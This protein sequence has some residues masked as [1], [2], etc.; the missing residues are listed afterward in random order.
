MEK[1]LSRNLD[2]FLDSDY[3]E[4][5]ELI[6]VNDGSTD[7]TLTIANEYQKS[8]PNT[9]IVIDKPNGHYGSCVNAALK[10]ATGKYFRIVDADDWVDSNSLIKVLQILPNIN[11]H[12][13]YTKYS[14]CYERD[15]QTIINEDPGNLIWYKPLNLNDIR[16]DKYVHMHQ[17][18]YLTNFLRSINYIQT[19]GVC[20]TDTEYVFM[21]IVQAQDV[22]CINVPLYQYFIGRDDQSMSTNVLMKNFSH[23]Y[24]VLLSILD[25]P[26]PS[27]T[28]NNYEFLLRYYV[29]TILGMLVDCLFVSR[30]LNENW[31]LQLHSV[32]N[33]LKSIDFDFSHYCEY[34]VNGCHWFKWWLQD[35]FISRLKLRM[36]FSLISIKH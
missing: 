9:I 7:K 32:C 34:S 13:V 12:V 2:S 15:G 26:R 11:T 14:N 18:T 33:R 25:Y 30:C 16:F 17:I 27:Y 28:N 21:P 3:I 8:Y 31:N 35:T 4:E 23:L 1:Y 24:K 20:Y 22:Y 6:V 5:I 10:I 29:N 36:L 19:E